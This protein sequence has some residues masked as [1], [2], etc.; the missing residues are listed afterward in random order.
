MGLITIRPISNVSIQLLPYPPE[1]TNYQIVGKT[2]I[3]DN[4]YIYLSGAR[5]LKQDYYGFDASNLIGDIEYIELYARIMG[6]ASMTAAFRVDVS[7]KQGL[8]Y[9]MHGKGA[10]D[11]ISSGQQLLNPITDLAWTIEDLNTL[12]FGLAVNLGEVGGEFRC[13][14]YYIIVKDSSPSNS[15]PS[16]RYWVG[17]SG[18]WDDTS[19]WATTSGGA[20][21]ASI[22][23]VD[24]DV[25]I[26][27]NS[28]SQDTGFINF[29]EE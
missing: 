17:N 21:G 10:W 22:P 15:S 28:F 27:E 9:A 16:N 13:S 25:I 4:S 23:S 18:N 7:T 3:D 11:L 19:H 6:P 2:N 1:E 8:G 26:D 14:Q 29:G 20:G 12:A 5:P 24:D